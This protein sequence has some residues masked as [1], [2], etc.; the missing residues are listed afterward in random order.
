MYI[1]LIHAWLTYNYGICLASCVAI[2]LYSINYF[3]WYGHLFHYLQNPRY[4]WTKQ[5]IRF[6]DTGH[7]ASFMILFYP[8]LI[9]LAH[10]IH[11]AIATGYWLGKYVFQ[12]KDADQLMNVPDLDYGHMD[13]CTY[14]HHTVPYSIVIYS[15][16]KQ[17]GPSCEIQYDHSNLMYTYAWMYAWTFFIYVPWRYYTG[18]TVYSILDQ[19]ITPGPMIFGFIWFIHIMLYVSNFVGYASCKMLH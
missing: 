15:I 17:H 19:K 12:L 6:T 9:P 2:K 4:N 3:Y 1:H 8:N 13:I 11:F 16:Y 18:D 7:L 10:N 5:F 14:I